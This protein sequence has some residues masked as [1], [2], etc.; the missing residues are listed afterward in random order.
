LILDKNL[1]KISE[2]DV[3]NEC[4]S[5]NVL[6]DSV[7][8]ETICSNCGIVLSFRNI[9]QRPEWR[10]F[11]A[12]EDA[13]RNRVGSPSTFTVHDKG[14]STVIDCQNKDASGKQLPPNRKAQLYRLRKWQLRIRIQSP[15][16]HNLAIAMAE[17][18]R[19][20]SQLGIPWNARE[21]AAI[22]YRRVA[23]KKLIRGHSIEAMIAAA[24]Y[25]ACR[26]Q[27]IPHDLAEIAR[28]VQ[29]NYKKVGQCYRLLRNHLDLVIPQVSPLDFIP[30]F[31][32]AL[33]LSEGTQRQ[34]ATILMRACEKGITVGKDPIGLAAAAL[35]IAAILAG[36]RR[37]QREIVNATHVT[38]ITIRHRYREMLAELNIHID[39]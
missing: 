32:T 17:L 14:L 18:D 27:K 39:V 34:A 2:T 20:S 29:K 36:E 4:G 31:S 35:Y 3:C 13:K 24:V 10:A 22:L 15:L 37:T 8:G 25:A 26:Q 6:I 30:R 28:S 16:D 9:D 19:L 23:E 5:A 21:T 12:E 1:P 38:E 11:S 7:R 33:N